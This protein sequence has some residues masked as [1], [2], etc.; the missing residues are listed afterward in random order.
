MPVQY[1]GKFL[2]INR[3][4]RKPKRLQMLKPPISKEIVRTLDRVV[5]K[6]WKCEC[7]TGDP[8]ACLNNFVDIRPS[9]VIDDICV[10]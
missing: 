5:D 7:K 4:C 3:K 8:W 10:K 1:S 6:A 9:V 2:G